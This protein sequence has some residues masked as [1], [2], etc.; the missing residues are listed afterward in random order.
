MTILISILIRD[1]V[2]A[3]PGECGCIVAGVWRHFLK[4]PDGAWH[5]SQL[6]SD[7]GTPPS[8]ECLVSHQLEH[9]GLWITIPSGPKLL[10][11]DSNS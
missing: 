11:V 5:F 8:Y 6:L 9:P 7:T 3:G 4:A 10:T 2:P 1:H